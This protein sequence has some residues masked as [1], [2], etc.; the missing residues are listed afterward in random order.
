MPMRLPDLANY[1]WHLFQLPSL[2]LLGIAL[3]RFGQALYFAVKS[4]KWPLATGRISVDDRLWIAGPSWYGIPTPD[5]RLRDV[6]Y[7]YREAEHRFE[8]DR[9]TLVGNTRESR[10]YGEAWQGEQPIESDAIVPVYLRPRKPIESALLPGGPVAK[11]G[12]LRLAYWA[13]F[14]WAMFAWMGHLGEVKFVA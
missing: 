8:S 6:R 5:R 13:L 1:P 2:A 10:L 14:W 12:I 4:P 11:W 3:F 9:V 7:T